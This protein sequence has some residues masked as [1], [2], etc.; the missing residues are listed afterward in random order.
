MRI[1]L[2]SR[3]SRSLRQ[4]HPWVFRNQI[5][6]VEGGP[7]TG[8]VVTV[9]D[10]QGRALGQGFYH[11]SSQIAFRFLTRDL[12]APIDAAFFEMRLARALALRRAA[13]G[14]AGH[15]RWLFSESDGVPGT[16]IDVYGDV[17]CWSTLCAGMDQRSELLLDTVEKLLAPR[18]I[19]E[20]NDSGLRAKDGLAERRG[21]CRGALDAPVVVEEEGLAFEVD[22]LGGPKTGFFLDQRLHRAAIRR[23]A[24]GRS[25]LDVFSAD[26]GFGLHAAAAGAREVLLLDASEPALARAERNIRRNG[27]ADRV[28]VEACDAL[29]RLAALAD[30]PAGHDLVILDPPAFAKSRRHVESARRAYQSINI[31]ALRLLPEGGILA[32]SSCSQAIDE[33][34]FATLVRYSAR[35][36]GCPVRVLYRGAQ[37]PDHPTLPGMPE[38]SYLKFVVVQKLGDELALP[39]A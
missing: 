1:R 23:F 18:A 39:A 19:V 29:E 32:T 33:R 21:L 25:V 4:G 9:E 3:Q 34:E 24:R 20:R 8:D 13:F 16:V 30:A 37:P 7:R 28:R 15:F 36:A 27:L 10:D 11:E 31:N 17:V 2:R 35:R 26:G 12:A 14:D 5:A 6:A 22:V 38:T